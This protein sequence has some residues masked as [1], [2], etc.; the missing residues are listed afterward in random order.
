MP[1]ADLIQHL[2]QLS[3]VPGRMELLTTPDHAQVVIDYAHTPDALA[4]A[5]QAARPHTAG[6]LW[7]VFGC[8]GNR[9]TAKRAQMG[10]IAARL[11][12]VVVVT[13]DNPRRED[14]AAIRAEII[15]A[16]P[17]AHNIADRAT[18]IE[19]ALQHA[20][21]DDLVL[22]AGKGHESTQIV[23]TEVLPYSDY[24][25]VSTLLAQPGH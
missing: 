24:T 11:A 8:G 12:D 2:P 20:G 15:S 21:P 10:E 22:V 18:A 6:K 16:A 14:P 17:R 19:Y 1:L 3:C 7:V 23:G 13:D 5:L 9:D 4:T 25:T